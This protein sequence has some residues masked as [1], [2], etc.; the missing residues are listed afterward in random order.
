MDKHTAMERIV[1]SFHR[2]YDVNTEDPIK[3]FHVEAVYRGID[4]QYLLTK[5][6]RIFEVENY[7]YV[8]FYKTDRL[9]KALYDELEDKAWTDGIGRTHPHS[10]HK[11][12][13]ITLVIVAENVDSDCE[14]IIKNTNRHVSHK[15]GFHG[16]SAFR[17]VV[18]DLSNGSILSNRRGS[19]LRRTV[20]NILNK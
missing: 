17:L 6:A 7:E 19:S 10:N 20:T 3:P 5:R 11:S 13:D 4:Q 18:C 9:T 8:Y 15:F 16:Y 1:D 2:Y 12:S 14:R